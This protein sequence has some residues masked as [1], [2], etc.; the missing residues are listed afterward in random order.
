M[1]QIARHPTL[2]DP[3]RSVLR[4]QAGTEE[5]YLALDGNFFA[6]YSDGIIE[7]L[8]MPTTSHQLIAYLL[9]TCHRAFA[10]G[11]PGGF[12]LL[13][14]LRVRLWPGKF[15]EPDVLY[16]LPEHL[17]LVGEQFWE[18]ADLVMEVVSEDRRRDL[19][20]KQLR[21]M[22]KRASPNT[23]SSTPSS[24]RSSS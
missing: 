5:E 15:R 14:P 24:A 9:C 21:G 4:H 8:P 11:G 6:E 23:G 12:G 13:A 22:L 7:F 17:H 20:V 10:A 16:V 3:D 1:N 2:D 18:G 19:G